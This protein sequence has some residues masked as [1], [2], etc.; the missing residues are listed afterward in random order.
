MPDDVV[1]GDCLN[2]G[3]LVV[4][5]EVSYLLIDLSNYHDIWFFAVIQKLHVY[6]DGIGNLYQS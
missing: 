2:K 4:G 5:L 3:D 1:G 6:I